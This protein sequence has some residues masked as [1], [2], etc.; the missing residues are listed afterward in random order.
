MRNCGSASVTSRAFERFHSE[1]LDSTRLGPGRFRQGRTILSFTA[2]PGIRPF[3]APPR[4]AGETP[5]L[6]RATAALVGAGLRYFTVQ[7]RDCVAEHERVL[8][9][10]GN[11]GSPVMPGPAGGPTV[12]LFFIRD[13]DGNWIEVVQRK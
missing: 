3:V 13:P 2:E 1:V 10:G 11:E 12:A 6:L 4:K 8:A 9:A 5:D 7:V